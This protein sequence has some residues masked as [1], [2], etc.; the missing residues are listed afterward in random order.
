MIK[1]SDSP[2]YDCGALAVTTTTQDAA[3]NIRTASKT[4]KVDT[5][6]PDAELTGDSSENK[7]G[8]HNQ[9]VVFTLDVSDAGSGIKN[10]VYTITDG[11]GSVIGK[12]DQAVSFEGFKEGAMSAT[13]KIE[14]PM[15]EDHLY[16][17]K[18]LTLKV[19]VYDIAGNV[20]QINSK[21]NVDTTKPDAGVSLNKK[22]KEGKTNNYF[23][24]DVDVDIT[25]IGQPF[26]S[27]INKL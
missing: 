24:K 18:D 27:K 9:K 26:R 22:T 1:K 21:V 8:W 5:T 15:V 25:G 4:I 13:G 20:N 2:M 6:K 12:E 16:D 10:A 7:D 3:G 14:I 17:Y 23:N 11:S 19:L